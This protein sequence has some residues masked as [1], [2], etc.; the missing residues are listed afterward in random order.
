MMYQQGLP[1]LSGKLSLRGMYNHSNTRMFQNGIISPA[2]YNVLSTKASLYLSPCSGCSIDYALQ[3]AYDDM[4]PA[5]GSRI[6][7]NNWQ[8]TA[9]VEIDNV[10]TVDLA[11]VLIVLAAVDVLR[12]ELRRAEE[13]A[14][15]IGQLRLVLHLYEIQLAPVILGEHVHAVLL[16]VLILLVAF[17]LKQLLY[18]YPPDYFISTSPPGPRPSSQTGGGTGRAARHSRHA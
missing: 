11:D 5:S 18:L 12:N 17:A 6:A 2:R 8:H 14:L 1:L 7:F 10:D 4:R 9:K 16:V 15:E 3:Y 13:H